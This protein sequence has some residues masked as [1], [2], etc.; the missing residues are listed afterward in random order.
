MGELI[1]NTAC[2][3]KSENKKMLCVHFLLLHG[4]KIKIKDSIGAEFENILS[5][6]VRSSAA[7]HFTA[8]KLL[9]ISVN[10]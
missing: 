2:N 8:S 1:L 10:T 9:S 4:R 7:N 3:Q 5:A 6:L